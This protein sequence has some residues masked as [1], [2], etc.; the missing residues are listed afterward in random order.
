VFTNR[1]LGSGLTLTAVCGD[2]SIDPVNA[3]HRRI[4]PG[5]KTK[6]RELEERGALSGVIGS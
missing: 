6:P 1:V 2:A 5:G 3:V 4:W